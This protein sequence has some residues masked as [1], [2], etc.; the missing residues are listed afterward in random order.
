MNEVAKHEGGGTA[1]TVKLV[2][3]ILIV[4]AGIAAFYVLKGQQ[5]DW[6][7]WLSFAL[8]LVIGA[9]I[10]ALS[11]HGRAAWKF[12]LDS[13]IELYKVFWPSRQETGMTTLVVFG[14]VVL[15]GAFFW[16]VDAIL[17]WFTKLVLGTSGTGTGG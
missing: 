10:F 13:R 8:A 16:G 11:Q 15:M 2:A 3:A 9:V 17:A 6:V 7:R 12:M 14:F 5:A 4:C 1:D